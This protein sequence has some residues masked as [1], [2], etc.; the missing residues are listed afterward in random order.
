MMT[1]NDFV[2]KDDLQ[3]KT[4]SNIKAFQV[5]SSLSSN[6]V[7]VFLRDGPFENDKRIVFLH[8]SNRTQWVCYM[9][10]NFFDSYGSAPPNKLSRF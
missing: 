6:D 3:I 8:L 1:F 10:E 9:D 2:Q 4:T 5:F 7:G